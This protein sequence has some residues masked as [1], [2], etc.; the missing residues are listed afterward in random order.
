MIRLLERPG[1]LLSMFLAI[2]LGVGGTLVHLTSP[3]AQHRVLDRPPEHL[4][5]GYAVGE[6]LRIHG[7]ED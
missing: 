2:G 5:C 7:E 4:Q 6:W 1:L 3:S